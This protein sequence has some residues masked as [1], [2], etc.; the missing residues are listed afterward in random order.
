MSYKYVTV[1]AE[2]AKLSSE[3]VERGIVGSMGPSNTIF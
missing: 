1:E 3:G 2:P